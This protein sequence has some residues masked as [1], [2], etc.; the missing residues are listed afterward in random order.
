MHLKVMHVRGY[1]RCGTPDCD[2]GFEMP[3]LS[4]TQFKKCYAAFR[5]HCV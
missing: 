4:E 3:D 5:E 1:I 2:W